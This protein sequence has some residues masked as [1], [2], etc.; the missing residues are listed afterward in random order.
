M[1]NLEEDIIKDALHTLRLVSSNKYNVF[2]GSD[3]SRGITTYHAHMDK[4]QRWQALFAWPRG[5]AIFQIF[6]GPLK[7]FLRAVENLEG[8][9]YLYKDQAPP[10]TPSLTTPL[11]HANEPHTNLFIIQHTY[12][13][14]LILKVRKWKLGYTFEIKQFAATINFW[15]LKIYYSGWLHTETTKK[16]TDH[17]NS[18]MCVWMHVS[19]WWGLQLKSAKWK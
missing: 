17:T 8:G 15:W 5:V 13:F 19:S 11:A 16:E 1:Q 10:P 4:D 12:F 6:K 7:N 9:H 14:L 18:T 2:Y 3:L